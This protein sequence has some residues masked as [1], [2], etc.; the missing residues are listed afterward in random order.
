MFE[1]GDHLSQPEFHAL[2]ERA[3]E[4][5][6]AELIAGVVYMQS[7]LKRS[8]GRSHSLLM[9]W[10]GSY[11]DE[12]PGVEAYDNATTIMNPDSEPQPDACLVI[13]PDKGGQTRF[14]LD[15]YLEG[16]PEFIGEVASSSQSIDLHAKKMDY[17]RA[18][19]CEYLVVAL[20]QKK[21]YWFINRD[22]KFEELTPEAD[23]YFHSQVFPGLWLDPSALIALDGKRVLSALRVG[24]A[25]AAHA[26]FAR[27]LAEKGSV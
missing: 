18:G 11:E 27:Q 23:G 12:T 8:H 24:L 14:T 26:Q 7:S 3:P 2:Y 17:Q 15:D 16:P 9:R 20:R 4:H 6:K 10:M 22:G 1:T 19:V 21:V 25:T 13:V 5:V